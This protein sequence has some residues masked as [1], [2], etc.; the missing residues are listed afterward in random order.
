[1]ALNNHDQARIRDYLLGHLNDEE[2]TKLEERL[3]VEDDL[4]EELEI[5]KGELIEEYC[6]GELNQN[7]RQWFEHNYLASAD[8]RQQ[9]VMALAIDC[10]KDQ[11]AAVKPI[12]PQPSFFEKLA[13]FWIRPQWA[14]VGSVVLVLVVAGI[15]LRSRQPGTIVTVGLTN[16]Q[17]SRSSGVEALPPKVNLPS[18][19]GELRA[20]LTLPK[21]F[22]QGTR[23]QVVLDNQ[24]DRKP[25]KVVDH[26]ENV[27]TVTIPAEDLPHGEYALE[28][29]ALKADGTEEAIP[30]NYR[31]DVD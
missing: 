20:S 7:D 10:L 27:V 22:P 25:V 28:L 5:S 13:A 29:T 1:M 30:G 9:H 2:L 21:S 14:A 3:M 12:A 19:A 24:T 23:F 17:L 16:T 6:A 31:F 4:F 15:W 11:P 18:G 8:G 26:K